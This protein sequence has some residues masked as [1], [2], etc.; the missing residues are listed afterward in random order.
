MKEV[1]PYEKFE[2]IMKTIIN[3][4]EKREKVGKFV[5]DELATS[6]F[7]IID[8]GCDIETVLTNLL[9]DEFKCWFGNDADNDGTC[10]WW[11][12]K[13]YGTDNDIEYWL[14][15]FDFVK[16]SKKCVYDKEGNEIIIT[17]LRQL[18]DYLI[19]NL[20]EDKK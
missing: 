8:F 2:K 12:K 11:K 16:D 4:S 5:E 20:T 19:S 6:S 13:H 15:G 3:F 14:Y 9:A 1:M 10:T 18:Y 17:S 7:C